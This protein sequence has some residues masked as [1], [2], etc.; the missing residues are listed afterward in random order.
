MLKEN[1]IQ[2]MKLTGMG[3]AK[4]AYMCGISVTTVH[5]IFNGAPISPE[6]EKKIYAYVQALKMGVDKLIDS[7]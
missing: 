1:V 2:I 6:T 4:L 3:K 7:I 5:N